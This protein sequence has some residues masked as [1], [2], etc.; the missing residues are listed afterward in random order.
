MDHFDRQKVWLLVWAKLFG[1]TVLGTKP[2]LRTKT[3]SREDQNSLKGLNHFW[4]GLSLGPI[5]LRSCVPLAA[6]SQEPGSDPGGGAA[7]PASAARHGEA[8]TPPRGDHGHATRTSN[9]E[10]AVFFL[11]ESW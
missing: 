8:R 10:N 4:G 3:I 2:F 7:L 6:G 11:G 9:A 5:L 1:K